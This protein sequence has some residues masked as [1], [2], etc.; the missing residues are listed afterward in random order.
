MESSSINNGSTKDLWRAEE[1]IAG[2]VEA[3]EALRELITFPVYYSRESQK[4]GL[5]VSI[6]AFHTLVLFNFR[7]LVHCS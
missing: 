4:L 7:S 1:A 6:Y 3:L 5:K 2:N